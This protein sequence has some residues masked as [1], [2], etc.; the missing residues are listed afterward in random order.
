MQTAEGA[1]LLTGATGFVGMELLAR[2]LE[3]TDRPVLAL[4][5]AGED[6]DCDERLRAVVEQIAGRADAYEDRVAAVC[7]DI[8]HEGLGLETRDRAR[9]ASEVTDIVHAAASVAFDL[10]LEESRAINVEGTRRVLEL[11]GECR[12]LRSLS[13]VSTAYVAGDHVGTFGEDQLD[14]G[15][16]FRNAYEQSKFEAERLV[17]SHADDLPVTIFRPSIVVGDRRTGWTRSFN[18]LYGPMRAF[19]R[20]TYAAVP[21]RSD[22]PVDVVSVDYVAD[23]ILALW[24]RRPGDGRT[25]HLTAGDDAATVGELIDMTAERFGRR[26]PVSL[27]PALYRRV[28]H[29]FAVRTAKASRKRMLRR[30]EVYFP[31][32]DV[33]VR[34]SD[35][36]T[37]EALRAARVRPRLLESYFDRLVDFAQHTDWGKRHVQRHEVFG[38]RR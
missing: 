22:A 15:Q 25:Y 29:P 32:F 34:F 16:G 5:R 28:V 23:A 36:R 27:P 24:R 6:G 18:V 17:R 35:R 9:L 12:N 11:A 7:G 2:F 30:S 8:T 33:R 19:E 14:V 21:A 38:G 20:G 26:A 4:I 1:V 37:R 3:Q 10:G 31:Y 13:Y